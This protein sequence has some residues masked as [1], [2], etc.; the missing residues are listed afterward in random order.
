M[1]GRICDKRLFILLKILWLCQ[2][3]TDAKS[4]LCARFH[5][6][7]FALWMSDKHCKVTWALDRISWNR[8]MTWIAMLL[9]ITQTPSEPIPVA[10]RAKAWVC[11]RSL[12]GIVVSNPAGSMDDCYELCVLSR[13]G[14]CVGLVTRPEESYRV[15]CIWVWSWIL[16]EEA[17]LAH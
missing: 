13:R 2:R 9:L 15:W 12:A 5:V 17:T 8:Y 10:A 11:G 3:L 16:D 14:L 4:S 1:S 7:P 6:W